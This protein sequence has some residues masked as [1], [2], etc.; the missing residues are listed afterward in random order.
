MF[1]HDE[2]IVGKLVVT[3]GDPSE[4]VELAEESLDL[5]AFA[6]ERLGRAVLLF[7]VRF[8]QYVGDHAL[9]IN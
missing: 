4:V 1:D 5:I 9:R 7:A 6:I 3:S 2:E 8:G